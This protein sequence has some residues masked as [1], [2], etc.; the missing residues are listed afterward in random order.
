MLE[1]KF[2]VC[3]TVGDNREVLRYFEPE[4]KEEAKAY[5][6]E[7]AKQYDQGVVSVSLGMLDFDRHL[8]GGGWM[9]VFEVYECG[10]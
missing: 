6:L 5:G 9:Q 3:H 8:L 7:A 4:Q 1:R 10:D 2:C